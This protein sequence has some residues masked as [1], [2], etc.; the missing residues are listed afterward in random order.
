MAHLKTNPAKRPPHIS[1][2]HTQT[3]THTHISIQ[4]C[5]PHREV[6]FHFNPMSSCPTEVMAP[7][8]VSPI[9]S[10]SRLESLQMLLLPIEVSFFTFLC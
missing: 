7:S 3:H 1:S 6:V 5:D 10:P 9:F 4:Q 2:K 8:Q